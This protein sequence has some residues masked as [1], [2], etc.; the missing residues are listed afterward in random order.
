MKKLSTNIINENGDVKKITVFVED[1]TAAALAEC[2]EEIRHLYILDEH[3][4][5]NL[6]RKE[7]RRHIRY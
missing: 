2:D 6:A 7:T 5:Q 1:E 4:A 3:E